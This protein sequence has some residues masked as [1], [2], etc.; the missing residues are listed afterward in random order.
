MLTA[1]TGRPGEGKSCFAVRRIIYEALLKTDRVVCTNLVIDQDELEKQLVA[2]GGSFN[3]DQLRI[4]PD[5]M[6]CDEY[7]P[8]RFW[9][10][11]PKGSIVVIDE[12]GEY[13]NS[14]DFVGGLQS[15]AKEVG[16][17]GRLHRHLEQDCFLITQDLSHIAKQ[18]RDLIAEHVRV[19]NLMQHPPLGL[20]LPFFLMRQFAI[21]GTAHPKAHT[22]RIFKHRARDFRLYDTRQHQNFLQTVE[23]EGKVDKE[24]L[25]KESLASGA[26][27]V[28]FGN[29]A[30]LLLGSAAVLIALVMFGVYSTVSDVALNVDEKTSPNEIETPKLDI[31]EPPP[32]GGGSRRRETVGDSRRSLQTSTFRTSG[33]RSYELRTSTTGSSGSGGRFSGN[34]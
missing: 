17:Y 20:K 32:D 30:V 3:P 5:P 23:G 16:V 10:W 31:V 25:G 28:L 7:N 29:P 34:R 14:Y 27:R 26:R 2:D 6:E 13:L 21:G 15:G 11:C 8:H 12:A 19:Y 9:E 24:K 1:I 18:L 33:V 22:F 4:L